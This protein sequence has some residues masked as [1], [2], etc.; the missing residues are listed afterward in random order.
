MQLLY[1]NKDAGCIRFTFSWIFSEVIFCTK[2]V[3]VV[4]MERSETN[5]CLRWMWLDNITQALKQNVKTQSR[6]SEEDPMIQ[7]KGSSMQTRFILVLEKMQDNMWDCIIKI[8]VLEGSWWV[9][10]RWN[11][12]S[13]KIFLVSIFYILIKRINYSCKIFS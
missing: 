11:G 3:V 1:T 6:F 7:L 2:F 4:T 13:S 8:F 5:L 9:K 12:T 10:G